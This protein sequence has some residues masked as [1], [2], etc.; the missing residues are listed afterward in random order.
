MIDELRIHGVLGQTEFYTN[1][2]G[3][4]VSKTIFYEE[5]PTYVRFFTRGNEFVITE[6]EIRYK[7]CGGSFCEWINPWMI[8]RRKMS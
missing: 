5:T 4:D 1:I 6:D 3:S 8:R 2:A 7:G